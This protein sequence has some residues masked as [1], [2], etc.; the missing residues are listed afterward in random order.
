MPLLLLFFS[1]T[2]THSNTSRPPVPA[3]VI[4][5]VH[6]IRLCNFRDPLLP[7]RTTL[8]YSC[9]RICTFS[10]FTQYAN[11]HPHQHLRHLCGRCSQVADEG[12]ARGSLPNAAARLMALRGSR[13][14]C[15]SPRTVPRRAWVVGE[16]QGPGP[17]PGSALHPP[18]ASL[19]GAS[20]CRL[21]CGGGGKP[22]AQEAPL[23][24]AG[25]RVQSKDFLAISGHNEVLGAVQ[26]F[27]SVKF[28]DADQHNSN[29]RS[30]DEL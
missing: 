7:P 11:E 21:M 17:S 13:S 2:Q 23:S 10:S 29:L 3:A 26:V 27:Q 16:G 12:L 6:C 4:G 24:F 19:G 9:T 30:P 14:P 15:P 18:R 5:S 8:L 1:L 20:L 25:T 22:P 28:S